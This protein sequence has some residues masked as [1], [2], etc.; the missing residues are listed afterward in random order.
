MLP[1]FKRNIN[2]EK[3]PNINH[4]LL[5]STDLLSSSGVGVSPN[6]CSLTTAC[7][8]FSS[9]LNHTALLPLS[10]CPVLRQ[11]LWA[12]KDVSIMSRIQRRRMSVLNHVCRLPEQAPAHATL[13]LFV[14]AHSVCKPH[15]RQQWWRP[16]GSPHRIHWIRQIEVDFEAVCRHCMEHR[17]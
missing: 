2:V 9:S 11:L 17:Q 12:F 7:I 16:R 6:T 15:N 4:V 14:E 3:K 13:R 8:T 5:R 1:H 10:L